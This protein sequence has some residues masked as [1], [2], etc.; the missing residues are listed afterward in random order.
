MATRERLADLAGANLA[1][2]ACHDAAEFGGVVFGGE[3]EGVGEEG[4]AEEHGRVGT[5]GAVRG[6]TAVAR[7]GAVEHVVVHEGG[8]VDEFDDAGAADEGFGGRAPAGT[9]GEDE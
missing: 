1:G 4:I 7:V 5:V 8:E 9:R 3:D 2:G 6:R